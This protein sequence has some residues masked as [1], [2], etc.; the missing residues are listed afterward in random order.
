MPGSTLSSSEQPTKNP[1]RSPRRRHRRPS[2]TTTRA[3][4]GGARRRTT[5][6]GRGARA[7]MSGPIIEASSSP[8]PT[9]T[10]GM[11]AAIASTSGSATAPDRDDD[12][13][14]HAALAG[15]AVAGGDRG[16]GGGVDVGV[17]QHDHVVL[18]AAER[19]HPLA[20]LRAG[21]VDVAGDRRCCPTNET[22]STSGCVSSA[23]TASASP[24]TTVTHAVGEAGLAAPARRGAATPTDPSPTA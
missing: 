10:S 9:T 4:V 21:L 20:V 24:C 23:S 12:R 1:S 5:A 19:L 18:G 7:V 13:D 16:V 6:P 14:R 11:R 2:T 8:G 15:R 17:G 22:A 3:F